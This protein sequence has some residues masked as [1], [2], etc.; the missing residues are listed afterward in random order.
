VADGGRAPPK[1]PTPGKKPARCCSHVVHTGFGRPHAL[2][3]RIVKSQAIV[4]ESFVCCNADGTRRVFVGRPPQRSPTSLTR[5]LSKQRRGQNHHDRIGYHGGWQKVAQHDDI[6]GVADGWSE[7]TRATT[8]TS[9]FGGSAP[10]SRA[11]AD[12]YRRHLRS[13]PPITTV[14]A[15]GMS[16]L[17]VGRSRRSER[18][19]APGRLAP[20]DRGSL[21]RAAGGRLCL[22]VIEAP[23]GLPGRT[24]LFGGDAGTLG[25][26]GPARTGPNDQ[27]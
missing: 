4:Q 27:G 7:D 21:L 6:S 16:L 22:W 24:E 17:L 18:Q 15:A 25:T 9:S 11:G 19:N 12:K 26:D 8:G 10:P 1:L 20:V 14:C 23:S 2:L 5:C 13:A 3:S